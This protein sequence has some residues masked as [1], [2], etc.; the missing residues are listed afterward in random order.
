MCFYVVIGH[1]PES[2]TKAL[3][4]TMLLIL[5]KPFTSIQPIVV[6]EVFYRL[7]NKTFYF[8]FHDAFAI[9]LSPHQF[10]VAIKGGCE[11]MVHNIRIA[12]EIHL[13]WVVLQVDITNAFN[14]ISH[15]VIF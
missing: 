2:M 12:L 15:R 1:I 5:A 7:V 6:G 9:H 14:I 8:Q 10:G 4:V 11:I 13:D 3:G